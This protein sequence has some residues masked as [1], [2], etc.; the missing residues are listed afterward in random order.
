MAPRVAEA[1]LAVGHEYIAITDNSKVYS[2]FRVRSLPSGV[3]VDNTGTI[4]AYAVIYT[5]MK[6][7][8]PVALQIGA[9]PGAMGPVIGSAGPHVLVS[10]LL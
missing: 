7:R 8:S 1:A 4:V 5:P 2:E 3:L 9:V 10:Q 6:R